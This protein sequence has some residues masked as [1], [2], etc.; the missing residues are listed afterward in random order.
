[1]QTLPV[2]T[3]RLS[4]LALA[5][6]V[7]MMVRRRGGATNL[8]VQAFRMV[9][10]AANGGGLGTQTA[11]GETFGR[12]GTIGTLP[13]STINYAAEVG[14]PAHNSVVSI[15]LN[16]IANQFSE[17]VFQVERQKRDG[18]LETVSNHPCSKLVTNPNGEYDSFTLWATTAKDRKISGN[19]YWVKARGSGGNGLPLQLWYVPYW[20]I[21]PRWPMDGSEFITDYLYRPGGRGPGIPIE[22]KSVVHFRA[23]LNPYNGGRTARQPFYPLLREVYQDNESAEYESA[24]TANMGIPGGMLSPKDAEGELPQEA[25]ESLVNLW[26]D[27]FTGSGRGSVLVPSH[28]LEYTKI[29]QS[30]A[31]LGI[32]ALRDRP[33]DRICAAL[34]VSPMV[35]GLTS[36]ASTKTYANYAEA[37]TAAYDDCI[38][39]LWAE[40]ARTLT[41]QLLPDFAPGPTERCG[42]DLRNVRALSEDETEIYNRVNSAYDSGWL[43]ADQA[44]V[45]AGVADEKDPAGEE[46]CKVFKIAKGAT[47][48]TDLTEAAEQAHEAGELGNAGAAAA[49]SAAG[50]EP[51]DGEESDDAASAD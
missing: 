41:M 6:S 17:P 18:N 38:L 34:G 28:A 25:R 43:R 35:L 50:E 21:F 31:E 39:P 29:G 46:A 23:D 13:G 51:E 3:G 42:W 4:R 15:G 32:A 14:D 7:A 47:V 49:N 37:R 26:A 5:T 36:G 48:V 33:E 12:Y 44:R 30:P 8:A 19:A 20:E 45:K 10:G 2:P 16:W 9:W 24:I 27:K 11:Y 40:F 22:R 1:M